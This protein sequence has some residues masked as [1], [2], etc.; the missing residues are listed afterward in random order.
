[1][2]GTVKGHRIGKNNDGDRDVVLLQVE[3]SGSDDIQTVELF[4]QC[5][6]DYIPPLGSDVIVAEIA[7][8][9]KIG[10]ATKDLVMPSMDEGERK[11]YSQESDI[12]KAYINLLK[13]GVIEINGNTD[14]AVRFTVLETQ[15]NELKTAFN[16]HVHGGVTAGAASTGAATPQSTA[17]LTGAKVAEVKL[18]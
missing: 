2:V 15:F 7:K 6:E 8:N 16:T 4:N 12:I 18:P 5:G 10:I 1:M 14:F 13:T 11:I 17:D 3:M 9:W